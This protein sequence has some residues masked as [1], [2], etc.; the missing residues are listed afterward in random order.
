MNAIKSYT[1]LIVWRK[2][3]F[4]QNRIICSN[5]AAIRKNQLLEFPLKWL[6]YYLTGSSIIKECV[7]LYRAKCNKV[8]VWLVD[9]INN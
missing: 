4:V 9:S 6:Y 3:W 1:V 7:L 5:F 8:T 2:F